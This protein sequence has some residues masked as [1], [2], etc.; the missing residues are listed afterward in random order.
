MHRAS[1][2]RERRDRSHTN[3]T[4]PTGRT[5][6]STCLEPGQRV[7][8]ARFTGWGPVPH[9]RAG[10]QGRLWH[11]VSTDSITQE[12]RKARD[13]GDG[14]GG[15][16]PMAEIHH[17]G[18]EEH[19][20]EA[21]CQN[22]GRKAGYSGQG[23]KAAKENTIGGDGA[24]DSGL[25]RGERGDAGRDWRRLAAGARFCAS[26][27]AV[28]GAGAASCEWRVA[29]NEFRTRGRARRHAG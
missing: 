20:G 23:R 24:K 19:E 18:H 16:R 11:C 4:G 8:G 28:G 1:S 2:V 22:S 5:H 26:W 21:L 27:A 29:R 25:G 10:R 9:R 15:W 7:W 6:P 13:G 3:A 12:W 14:V 17:E